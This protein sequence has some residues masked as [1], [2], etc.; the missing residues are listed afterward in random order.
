MRI[1]EL[2]AVTTV[3]KT[4]SVIAVDT[5]AGTKQMSV[6]DLQGL[7][8]NPVVPKMYLNENI[9]QVTF[10]Y[11]DG[12]LIITA[13]LTNNTYFRVTMNPISGGYLV[14]YID[15]NGVETVLNPITRT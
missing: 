8:V 13:Y 4:T 3:D 1:K 10:S 6:S 2:N 11:V 7:I 15:S 9:T 14:A 12:K 5:N